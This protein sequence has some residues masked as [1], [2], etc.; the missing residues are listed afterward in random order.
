M[1]LVLA[2]V[3]RNIKS[4]AWRNNGADESGKTYLFFF[5]VQK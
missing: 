2:G 5:R 3:A 4:V 1:S